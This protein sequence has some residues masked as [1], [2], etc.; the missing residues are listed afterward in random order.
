MVLDYIY[1]TIIAILLVFLGYFLY[2]KEEELFEPFFRKLRTRQVEKSLPR[3]DRRIVDV[4]CGNLH[5][6]N[7]VKFKDKMGI[8]RNLPKVYNVDALEGMVK[9]DNNAVSCVTFI[10]ALEHFNIKKAEMLI[11]ESYRVL[12]RNG[13][14]IMTVPTKRS[15]A[16]ISLL[17]YFSLVSTELA[18][19]HNYFSKEEILYLLKNAGFNKI[20]YTTFEFGLNS[21]IVAEK[22]R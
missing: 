4:G 19:E 3:D 6:L 7:K 21:L 10:A 5:F 8:D 14:L 16:I 11:K 12:H 13:K 18:S 9:I 1:L 22:T 2:V 17:A 20:N 15:N